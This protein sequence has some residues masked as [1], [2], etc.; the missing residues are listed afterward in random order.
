MKGHVAGTFSRDKI[1][2]GAH[3]KRKKTCQ[4]QAQLSKTDLTNI[5]DVDIGRPE[6]ADQRILYNSNFFSDGKDEQI[7]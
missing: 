4:G 3:K 7:I 2:T 5:L 6:S 1:T